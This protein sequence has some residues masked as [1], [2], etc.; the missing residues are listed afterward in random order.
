[1][2]SAVNLDESYFSPRSIR[3]TLMMEPKRK[4]CNIEENIKQSVEVD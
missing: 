2:V 3:Y 1:M 4:Q